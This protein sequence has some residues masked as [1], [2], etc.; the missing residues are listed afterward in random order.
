MPKKAKTVV[1]KPKETKVEKKPVLR[2][3]PQPAVV[4]HHKKE[5]K[6]RTTKKSKRAVNALKREGKLA[7]EFR[8]ENGETFR[9]DAWFY[10]NI[11]Q[12][13]AIRAGC[14]TGTCGETGCPFFRNEEDQE[15]V[16]EYMDEK[17]KTKTLT[18]EIV[19]NKK[20]DR[21]LRFLL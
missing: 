4:E 6:K 11:L 1:K 12:R 21:K 20:G 3:K 19:Q 8:G 14:G 2:E 16:M 5:R 15:L 10:C 18:A 17:G 13:M 7:R 9:A